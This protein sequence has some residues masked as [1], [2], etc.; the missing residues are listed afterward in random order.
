MLDP[1]IV[2]IA[3]RWNAVFPTNIIFE[4][5]LSPIREV[6]RRICHDKVRFQG[7]MQVVEESISVIR[8]EVSINT[9]D[10]HIH[11]SH[12]PSISIGLLSV[13]RNIVSVTAMCLNEFCTL[14]EHTARTTAW[15][16]VPAD[17]DTIEKAFS[18]AKT[19]EKG[20]K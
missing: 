16:Y 3:R 15:I 12:F 7:L 6:E 8:S 14:Y 4:F 20:I 5:I 17:F 11:F 2:G 19:T 10:S 13:N 1:R 18:R 9:T